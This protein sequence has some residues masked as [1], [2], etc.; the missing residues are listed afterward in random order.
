MFK[1]FRGYPFTAPNLFE[2]QFVEA[3]Q[4][5]W[6]YIPKLIAITS[7]LSTLSLFVIGNFYLL[8]SIFNKKITFNIKKLHA[9]FLSL[10]YFPLIIVFIMRPTL[11]DSWRHFLF[12]TIPFII[13][14]VFGAYAI[15]KVKNNLI[16]VIIFSLI[17]FN[18][19]QTA[20]EMK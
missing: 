15:F 7:P 10:L 8:S 2:G 17:S 18:L 20:F 5:P 1:A 4:L 3:N 12:L 6:Y 16:K 14:A 19:L 9:Y 13:I 11:Y